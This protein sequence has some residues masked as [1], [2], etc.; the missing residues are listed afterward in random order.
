MS[1]RGGNIK[2]SDRRMCSDTQGIQQIRRSCVRK[3]KR[4]GVGMVKRLGKEVENKN[5]RSIE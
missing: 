3:N 1:G 2:P 4:E 5:I